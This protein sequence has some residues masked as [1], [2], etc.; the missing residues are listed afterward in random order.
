MRESSN[1]DE[2]YEQK[3]DEISSYYFV[4]HKHKGANGFE[5]SQLTNSKLLIL[6]EEQPENKPTEEE[7]ID[8]RQKYDDNPKNILHLVQTKKSQQKVEGH[9]DAGHQK[10]GLSG[11]S[12]LNQP[13]SI[14]TMK[15]KIQK[16]LFSKKT[17]RL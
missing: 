3:S 6:E 11:K 8:G 1:Y 7:E 10:N 2:V 12:G 9:Q 4:E 5:A 17:R 15:K 14:N 13:L 16:S